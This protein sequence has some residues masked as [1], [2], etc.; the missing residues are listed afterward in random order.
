MICCSVAP[1]LSASAVWPLMQYGHCVVCATATAISCLVTLDKAPSANTAALKALKACSGA[2]ASSRRLRASSTVEGG[3]MG[4][5]MGFA[6]VRFSDAHARS[7]CGDRT[8]GVGSIASE[9]RPRCAEHPA[10]RIAGGKALRQLLVD[11]SFAPFA[12]LARITRSLPPHGAALIHV[13]E[14]LDRRHDGRAPVKTLWSRRPRA[15][16]AINRATVRPAACRSACSH[17][18]RAPP[19]CARRRTPP[20]PPRTGSAPTPTPGSTNAPRRG[21]D[22][23]DRPC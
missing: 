4:D 23:T 15:A 6:P 10:G 9:W 16:A 5:S 8:R 2:G 1:C 18:A 3:Y 14:W 17:R 21:A 12:R 20:R 22:Q 11:A 7:P 19:T 13:R